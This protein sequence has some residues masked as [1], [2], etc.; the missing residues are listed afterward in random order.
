MSR[1]AEARRGRSRLL[2]REP[3]VLSDPDDPA[4]PF[5]EENLRVILANRARARDAFFSPVAWVVQ[6]LR[7]D[8]V[9]DACLTA[10]SRTGVS[11]SGQDRV[12]AYLGRHPH[13][14]NALLALAAEAQRRASSGDS[15]SLEVYRDPEVDSEY[16]LLKLRRREYTSDT[17]DVIDAVGVVAERLLTGTSGWILVTADFQPAPGM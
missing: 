12:R 10:L 13:L 1:L 9:A 17:L 15:W 4:T 8:L 16:L 2:E 11:V 14:A 5:A 7:H 6:G 3:Y